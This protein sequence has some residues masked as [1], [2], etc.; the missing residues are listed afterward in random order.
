MTH[1][2]KYLKSYVPCPPPHKEIAIRYPSA[3]TMIE[4]PN[5]NPT[6][7]L[8]YLVR[9]ILGL[10]LELKPRETVLIVEAVACAHSYNGVSCPSLDD[11]PS[12]VHSLILELISLYNSKATITPHAP[13][14]K[15]IREGYHDLAITLLFVN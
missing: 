6:F 5:A 7:M 12:D 13:V 3:G 9:I 1:H 14:I 10:A 11:R 8:E 2:T 4:E 15:R